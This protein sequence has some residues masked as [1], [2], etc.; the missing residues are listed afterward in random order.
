M[1]SSAHARCSSGDR[2]PPLHLPGIVPESKSEHFDAALPALRR[3][4]AKKTSRGPRDLSDALP[5]LRQ[6]PGCED[7]AD[8]TMLNRLLNDASSNGED[9]DNLRGTFRD[10]CDELEEILAGC[11]NSGDVSL[12]SASTPRESKGDDEEG[13]RLRESFETILT[14]ISEEI[15]GIAEEKRLALMRLYTFHSNNVI[16]SAPVAKPA[17][18]A[19]PPPKSTAARFVRSVSRLMPSPFM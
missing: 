14:D 11:D 4:K 7:V 18:R 1:S 8:D 16:R 15:R 3:T 9:A 10:D 5:R 13:S 6:Q 12:H 17:I 2:A 19:R